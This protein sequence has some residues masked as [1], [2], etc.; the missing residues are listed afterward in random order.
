MFL[1]VAGALF[2]LAINQT[3]Q[4]VVPPAPPPTAIAVAA[5][6]GQRSVAAPLAVKNPVP[7]PAKG[8][9]ELPLLGLS[10]DAA[11]PAGVGLSLWVRPEPF[12]RIW[13]GPA[14]NYLSWGIQ[15]GVEL[16]PFRSVV[17]PVLS[18]E[19]GRYFGANL[20]SRFHF[21]SSNQE[22]VSVLDDVI[23]QYGAAMIGLEF[24]SQRGF[25]FDLRVGL[26]KVGVL[27]S[28]SGTFQVPVNVDGVSSPAALTLSRPSILGVTP[29][30]KLGFLYW[31]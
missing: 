3:A 12:L 28:S 10:L 8:A 25:S 19:A 9:D 15:G 22:F 21:N 18:F 1:A 7:P 23:V 16:A 27:S 5:A 13:A 17:T 20:N 14:W 6:S 24:G 30:L 29:A 31:F 4:P 26:A 11:I 2:A